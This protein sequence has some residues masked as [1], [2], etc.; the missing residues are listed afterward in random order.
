[1]HLVRQEM[2]E[3]S[4]LLLTF[5]KA[6]GTYR[7]YAVAIAWGVGLIGWTVVHRM[8]DEYQSTARVYVDTQS[9]LKPLMA[10]MT[11]MPNVEE[12][13]MFMRRTLISRPN[14]E[15]VIRMVDLDIKTNNANGH[16]RL[17]DELTS[18][19][20]ISGTGNDD[21]YT[22]SYTNPDPRLGKD[23]VQS[24]LTIFVEGSVG[25][26]KQDSDKAISFIADQIK[27]YEDKLAAGENALKDFKIR[28]MGMMSRE[29]GDYASKLA[30][31]VELL[32]QARLEAAESEQSRN[33][34]KRQLAGEELAPVLGATPAEDANPEL[35][36]RIAAL[37]K[38]LDQLRMQYT[39]EHPD[40]AGTKRLIDQLKSRKRDEASKKVRTPGANFGP[41][42]QQMNVALSVEEARLA[43]LQTR[44][45]EYSSR[46][47]SLRA[48]SSAAP[49]VEAELSQL[50]R[51]YQVNKENY[52][53]LVERREAARL[54][55]DLSSASDMMT[56]RV[57]DPP[58]APLVPVG[59]NRAR[60]YS[61]VFAGALLAGLGAALLLSQIRPT[62]ISQRSLREITGLP[63]LGGISMNWT[64]AQRLKRRRRLYAFALAVSLF[65]GGYGGVMASMLW[66]HH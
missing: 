63:I 37:E 31:T 34:I 57:I 52:A 58:S 8:P 53:K 17:I 54:S 32:S 45:R 16:E 42:V 5:L 46:V 18:Q 40:I 60:L 13:V 25:G 21:I 12:Q 2:A 43:A 36:G 28:H 48:M 9:I 26:K 19:I 22:I 41:M 56:I 49:E 51:D 11:T 14:V 39:D 62:F 10:G 29:G 1:V 6:I 44:V 27:S 66:L 38:S 33:A 15:R 47:A 23:V 4:A 3:L 35:D 59:P 61:L 64:D 20:S 50:N 24:L 55:G 7:W 65:F 30:E